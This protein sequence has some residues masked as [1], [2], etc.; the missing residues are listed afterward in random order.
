M[1]HINEEIHGLN[2]TLLSGRPL[3]KI[4][5]TK[6]T[7]LIRLIEKELK[8]VPKNYYRN[9]W[10]ALG[11]SA[12]GLPIGVGIGL[13]LGNMAYLGI[14]LPI[15]LGLGAVVGSAMDKRAAAEGRQL[16]MEIK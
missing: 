13:S 3:L 6:Q 1:E 4:F 8:I 9:L 11:M 12:F 7:K 10:I 5:K 2:A 16:D 15:G 14:G